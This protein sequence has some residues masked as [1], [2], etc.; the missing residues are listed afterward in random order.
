MSGAGQITGGGGGFV[1][2]E[3][4]KDIEKRIIDN[5]IADGVVFS[6][7]GKVWGGKITQK[8]AIEKTNNILE[9]IYDIESRL[10]IKLPKVSKVWVTGSKRGAAHGILPAGESQITFAN[11]WSAENWKNIK[12]WEAKHP[13]TNWNGN[14]AEKHTV[15]NVRHEYGHI[16]DG[17]IGNKLPGASKKGRLNRRLTDSDEF[18]AMQLEV[19]KTDGFA[20]SKISNYAKTNSKE[21]FAEAFSQYTSKHYKGNFPKRLENYLDGVLDY[22]KVD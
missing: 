17:D 15:T 22:Y 21:W 18:K 13:R 14:P 2:I 3:K 19:F 4:Y 1:P 5:N 6:G 8:A 10:K 7:G 20:S 12:A 16:I 9:G 11:E